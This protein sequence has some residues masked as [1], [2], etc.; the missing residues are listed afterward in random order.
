MKSALLL[1]ASG[2]TGQHCLHGLLNNSNYAKV[3]VLV[4]QKLS[5]THPKLSQ[6]VVD[7][8]ALPNLVKYFHVDDVF[9][10]IG[11]TL[12]KAKTKAKFYAV[13]Y[14]LIVD[15]ATLALQAKVK[16]FAIVS[17]AGVTETSFNYYSATKGKL[18]NTLKQMG[19]ERLIIMKPSLLLGQRD[20]FRLL[21]RLAQRLAPVFRW[22]CIGRFKKFAP[23]NS[24]DVAM[25]MINVAN[26]LQLNDA[27]IVC[28]NTQIDAFK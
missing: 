4:R 8:C 26:N 21:E 12:K 15:I 22:L 17:A 5:L 11:T 6:H 23:T 13:D 10:C 18:E 27:I 14:Q 9:C 1:G 24:Q 3:I 2:L 7:F 16:Q 28:E 20:E 25:A 19:F